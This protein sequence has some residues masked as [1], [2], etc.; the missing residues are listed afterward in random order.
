M[1]SEPHITS[2]SSYFPN[3]RLV[4]ILSG[5][6]L[7]NASFLGASG[8]ALDALAAHL[9]DHAFSSISGR[10][11]LHSAAIIALTHG[12]AVLAL[13]LGYC[14]GGPVLRLLLPACLMTGGAWLFVLSVSLHALSLTTQARPAPFGGIM[15]ILAWLGLLSLMPV[16]VRKTTGNTP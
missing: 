3:N 13:C 7:I 16:L 14:R 5:F 4:S 11:H 6:C 8:I 9:P 2:F 1:P 15:M 10:E 12:I